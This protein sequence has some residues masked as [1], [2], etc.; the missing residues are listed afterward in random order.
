MNDE[1]AE[2]LKMM[3]RHPGNEPIKHAVAVLAEIVGEQEERIKALE[4]LVPP[5]RIGPI[6]LTGPCWPDSPA[7]PS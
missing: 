6:D 2:L 5:K 3:R 1:M 7:E 4:S